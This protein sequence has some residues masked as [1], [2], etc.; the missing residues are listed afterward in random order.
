M[1]TLEDLNF[2]N[3][4]ELQDWLIT[5]FLFQIP[6]ITK[7][8]LPI[9]TEITVPFYPKCLRELTSA[10]KAEWWVKSFQEQVD[11]TL[12]T[13]IQAW[14]EAGHRV[15]DAQASFGVNNRYDPLTNP[16]QNIPHFYVQISA[17]LI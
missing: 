2:C 11:V 3:E 17:Y 1:K 8:N 4:A 7:N 16:E 6:V 15:L 12:M 5:D 10:A 9:R 13:A 14:E